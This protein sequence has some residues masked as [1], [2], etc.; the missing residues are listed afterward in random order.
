MFELKIGRDTYQITE[1]DRF[2][3]NGACVQLVTQK[4]RWENYSY[5]NI[6]LTQKAVREIS[7]FEKVYLSYGGIV[8]CKLYSLVLE[9]HNV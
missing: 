7:K 3:D 6:V 8:D 4:G 1:N 2:L 5:K 9:Q